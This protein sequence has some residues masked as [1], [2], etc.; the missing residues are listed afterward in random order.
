MHRK[1]FCPTKKSFY[2]CH[3]KL[4]DVRGQGLKNRVALRKVILKMSHFGLGFE[5]NK[6]IFLIKIDSY[7]NVV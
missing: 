7:L 6:R 3:S 1:Q 5:D 4:Y 2:L